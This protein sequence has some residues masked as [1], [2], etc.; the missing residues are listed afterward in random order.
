V[1]SGDTEWWHLVPGEPNNTYNTVVVDGITTDEDVNLAEFRIWCDPAQPCCAT[2]SSD[3]WN[4]NRDGRCTS[5][6]HPHGMP[7][8]HTNR[9][10]ACHAWLTWI[11][12]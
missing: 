2:R 1:W 8:V 12:P 5:P 10:A 11:M 3:A 4:D 6:R 7:P 9:R